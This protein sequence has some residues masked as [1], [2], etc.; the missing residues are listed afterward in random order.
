MNYIDARWR[1][2]GPQG[3][4]LIKPPWGRVT[5]IDLNTGDHLWMVPHGDTPDFVRNHPALE[6]L[7]IPK[8][9]EARRAGSMV[10]PTLLFVAGGGAP[11]LYVYDKRTGETI[12]EIE[13]PAGATGTPMTYMVDGRQYVVVAVGGP[14]HPAELVALTSR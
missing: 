9:G 13:L 4:P 2:D 1:L 6:G 14:G 3:L 11:W 5:A 8:T 10:T 12:A 7:D